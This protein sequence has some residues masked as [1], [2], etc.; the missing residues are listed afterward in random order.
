MPATTSGVC[1]PS[2]NRR[3][4]SRCAARRGLGIGEWA[5]TA[6]YAGSGFHYPSGAVVQTKL[7]V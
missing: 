5:S 4:P 3:L 1:P 2:P 6:A 7:E